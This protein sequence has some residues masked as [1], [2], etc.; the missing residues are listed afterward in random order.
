MY[1]RKIFFSFLSALDPLYYI[2]MFDSYT[3]FDAYE[4]RRAVVI[5]R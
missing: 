4:T 2:T 1:R 5:T 3:N